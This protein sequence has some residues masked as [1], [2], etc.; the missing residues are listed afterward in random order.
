[1][2]WVLKFLYGCW[3]WL[4]SKSCL[5]EQVKATLTSPYTAAKPKMQ[6][7]PM[8][9]DLRAG[10]RN[11]AGENSTAIVLRL[12]PVIFCN[13]YSCNIT[14]KTEEPIAKFYVQHCI[15]DREEQVFAVTVS[16]LYNVLRIALIPVLT[17]KSNHSVDFIF[18]RTTIHGVVLPSHSYRRLCLAMTV[19]LCNKAATNNE[20]CGWRKKTIGLSVYSNEAKESAYI[21]RVRVIT[22]CS[23]MSTESAR[24]DELAVPSRLQFSF[25]KSVIWWPSDSRVQVPL[26]HKETESV[27]RLKGN[28]NRINPTYHQEASQLA[29]FSFFLE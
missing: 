16:A 9:C 5:G 4:R 6:A 28:E 7:T 19:R 23:I 24:N 3:S 2:L 8:I 14:S 13:M 11:A 15:Q 29:S 17:A 25:L 20:T 10:I 12:I 21:I 27:T 18:P 1:M 26:Q 22:Y